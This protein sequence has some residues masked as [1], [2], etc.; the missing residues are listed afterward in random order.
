MAETT[1]PA[2]FDPAVWA[3]FLAEL[4]GL[5]DRAKLAKAR[6]MLRAERF[7]LFADVQSDHVCGVVRAQST[8]ARLYA[9][10]LASDG[11]FGCCTQNLIMDVGSRGSVCKHLLV[12]I[13]GLVRAGELKA[14]TALDWLHKSRRMVL[15]KDGGKPDRDE[16]AGIFLRYRGFE[17]GEIDWRPTETIP[18]DF[19]AL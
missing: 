2:T 13:V 18:E 19:Y 17:A 11:R 9:C 10:R 8:D 3:N 1:A 16:A 5:T 6:T 15:T 4:G 14:A 12:L 7:Q